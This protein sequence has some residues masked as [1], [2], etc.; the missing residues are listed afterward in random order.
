MKFNPV[1]YAKSHIPPP[2]HQRTYIT[3]Y[4]IG[5]VANGAF[6][7][8]Y[9]LYLTQIV[10]ISTSKTAMAIA[11]AGLVGLPLTLVAGDLA[12]RLGPRRVVLFGLAGQVAG[13]AS[14]VFIQGFWSLL[15]IV[16]SMNVF[17][18]AYMASE[19]A[20]LR[21]I[22]G[23]DTVTFRSQ[24]QVLGSIAVTVGAVGA[25]VGITI[26]TPAAYRAMFLAVAGVYLVVIA[27]TLRL[28]DYKPLPKPQP[29]PVPAAP[30]ADGGPAGVAGAADGAGPARPQRWLVLRDKPFMAYSVV[31]GLMTVSAFVEH[32]LLPIWIAVFTPAP[33][34]TVAL[35]F[36]ASTAISVLLQMRLSTG[37]RTT[38][39]AGS[40]MRR[41]G[42]MLLLACLTLVEMP[43]QTP[44][45]ATVLVVAGVGFISL[46]Q[47]Y[48]ISGR[49]VFEF[50]LP[51]AHAQGQYD[52][53][54]N[55]IMT[56]SITGAPL[57]LIGFVAN[58]GYLG[59]IVIGAAF[60]VLGLTGPSIA[61]W[62]DRTRPAPESPVEP[63]ASTADAG[64]LVPDTRVDP[65]AAPPSPVH[66][67]QPAIVAEA[68]VAAPNGGQQPV[69]ASPAA[70]A[71]APSG[72]ST[73]ADP[74]VP[75]TGVDP[76][77][78]PASPVHGGQPAVVAE[79]APNGG[80]QPVMASAAV[81]ALAPSGGSNGSPNGGPNGGRSAVVAD[82]EMD[83]HVA[84]NGNKALAANGG[85]NTLLAGAGA[86]ALMANGGTNTIVANDGAIIVLNAGA[87][88]VL[89]AGATIVAN[90]P[91][92]TAVDDH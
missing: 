64:A 32:Q 20:L 44:A 83:T 12:D 14:Y 24:V 23:D 17:A 49:F 38:R 54:L 69:M 84:N 16:M 19:G 59:W 91:E 47:I 56:L 42:I 46:A 65:L 15:I 31:S 34:W 60:L 79:A 27:I 85:A 70:G 73:D 21:R 58:Q 62:A 3:A 7:P 13:I 51:P 39:E 87:T 37:V 75:D 45:G 89:N 11:I 36:V 18:Y 86:Y 61:A 63:E 72:R 92:W 88:I 50:N 29:E 81:G 30:A 41:A 26:G 40:S 4:A 22:G 90:P 6:L 71:L 53:F 5:M 78:A 9:V 80:Q 67:G 82:G 48:L 35:A 28:P 55:T 66:G 57:V 2:G 10:G 43:Y 33:R 8:I 68:A 1:Q 76:I 77:A 52:G 25:G 74:L